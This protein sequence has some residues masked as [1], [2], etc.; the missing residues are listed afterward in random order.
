M[1]TKTDTILDKILNEKVIE[2]GKR[3]A[4]IG[5]PAVRQIAENSTSDTRSFAQALQK[6]TVALIA[7]VKKASPSKG[8]L[9]ED[10]DPVTIGKLYDQNGASAISVL[11]DE[12]FFMGHL[13][14]M[15]QV[16]EA[17]SI[18]V[19]RKDF[20]VHAY[21]IYEARANGA[22]AVL[23]IVASLDDDKLRDFRLLI[24][25]LG[26]TALVEVHD[27]AELDRALLSG[28]SVIGVNNRDLRTFHVDLAVTTRIAQRLTPEHGVILVAESGIANVQDIEGMAE[29]GASAVL[30]GETLVKSGVSMQ[31]RIREFASV[32]RVKTS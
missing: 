6:E 21:Q 24:E 22:D 26:M 18:P 10:F 11:T 5:L 14:H 23:L 9:I 16:R 1:F 17:V 29:S 19:L 2:I 27:E 8:I 12:A 28:A 30:V 3:I 4:K 20:V 15:R 32:R 25:S 7:E 31:E 13:D